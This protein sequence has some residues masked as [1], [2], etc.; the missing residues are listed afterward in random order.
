MLDGIFWSWCDVYDLY[1]TLHDTEIKKRNDF[2]EIKTTHSKKGFIEFTFIFIWLNIKKN[3][4]DMR[5]SRIITDDVV[6]AKLDRCH[7]MLPAWLN[8]HESSTNQI[9]LGQVS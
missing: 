1:K 2:N 4:C 8:L 3:Y 9:Q 7:A 6:S 5:V